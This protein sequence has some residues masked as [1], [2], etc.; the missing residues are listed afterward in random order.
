MLTEADIRGVLPQLRGYAYKI[1]HRVRADAEDLVQDALVKAWASRKQFQDGTNSRAWLF[2][3]LRT[4][5][6]SN[7]RDALRE[8]R[9]TVSIDSIPEGARQT[10]PA[11]YLRVLLGDVERELGRLPETQRTAVTRAALSGDKN[12][13]IAAAMGI[14]PVTFSTRLIRGREHL[15]KEF[16]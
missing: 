9:Q 16:A 6:A 15:R 4:V 5:H 3:V 1:T 13:D 12:K 7:V 11:A 2:R 10:A 14:P 8:K